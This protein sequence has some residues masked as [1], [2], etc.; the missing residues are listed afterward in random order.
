[1]QCKKPSVEESANMIWEPH[2]TING[3][4]NVNVYGISQ[5]VY[6]VHCVHNTYTHIHTFTFMRTRLLSQEVNQ[7]Y[8]CKLANNALSWFYLLFHHFVFVVFHSLHHFWPNLGNVR[9]LYDIHIHT[10]TVPTHVL[11]KIT[12]PFSATI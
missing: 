4:V 6:N 1:M 9:K 8:I 10:H 12:F 3:E 7:S 5:C 2:N 11:H